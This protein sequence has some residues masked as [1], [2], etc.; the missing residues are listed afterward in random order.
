MHTGQGTDATFLMQGRRCGVETDNGS[1]N[2][3]KKSEVEPLL[4]EV[5]RSLV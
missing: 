3:P 5:L 2:R 4:H 1:L